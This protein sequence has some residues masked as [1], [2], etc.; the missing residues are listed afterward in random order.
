[1]SSWERRKGERA[2]KVC[3]VERLSVNLGTR[4]GLVSGNF[5]LNRPLIKSQYHTKMLLFKS[6]CC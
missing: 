4:W 5:F 1:V 3:I 6:K 2:Y